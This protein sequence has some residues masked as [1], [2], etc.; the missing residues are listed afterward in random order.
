M[1]SLNF[2]MPVVLFLLTLFFGFWVKALG[3]PYNGILFNFHKLIAL[4]TV[5]IAAV[6]GVGMLK[7]RD[8]PSLLIVPMVVLGV[9][10]IALFASGAFLSIGNLDYKIMKATHNVS[11]VLA[12]ISTAFTIYFLASV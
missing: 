11:L 1:I 6:Q 5:V 2:I 4:G 7:G 3:K 8:I 12:I 9:C 10:V